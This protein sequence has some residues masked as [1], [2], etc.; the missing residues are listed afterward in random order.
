VTRIASKCE[1]V[2]PTADPQKSISKKGWC[3]NGFTIYQSRPLTGQAVSS[4]PPRSMSLW[5]GV[6]SRARGRG[7]PAWRALLCKVM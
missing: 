3:S 6:V 1:H 4:L 7:M 5:A 2:Y